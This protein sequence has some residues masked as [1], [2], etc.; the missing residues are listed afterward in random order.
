MR[1]APLDTF[2]IPTFQKAIIEDEEGRPKIIHNAP[3]PQLW[4][5]DI[6]VKTRMVALNPC[7]YKMGTAFPSPGA[8]IGNDF[9]GTVVCI[10]E[11][12]M[13]TSTDATRVGDTVC[14]FVH[15]S[16]PADHSSGAFAEYIRAPADLV[17][18]VPKGLKIEHAATL[19]LSLA[20][21]S[22]ALWENGLG[23]DVDPEN[24][25]EEPFPIL[26]YGASTSTG[27]VA[28]QL[29]KLSGIN[30]IIATCSP[31]NFELVRAYGAT[32]IF[33]YADRDTPNMI[34]KETNGELEYALD[35]IADTD[36]VAYCYASISR[37]GGHYTCLELCPKE[38][39]Q[40]RKTVHAKFPLA[41]EVFGKAVELSRGYERPANKEKRTVA[42]RW[43]QMFQRL[44]DDGK[45]RVP[46]VKVLSPGFES[47]L[48]GLIL[49]Q[50]GSISGQKLVVPVEQ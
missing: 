38:L 32:S 47:I 19:G 50:S 43:F 23:L 45:L 2:A 31:R 35:I 20:T 17:L 4:P 25:A 27:L 24:R 49:L 5:G 13:A 33:N 11:A 28:L 48:D 8:V 10:H 29:L 21:A 18:R 42:V 30:P 1:P 22:V 16:N 7:D 39:L 40:K 37:F 44:L 6:L 41:L 34:R 36:S 3:V 15:G 9:V 26:V 14:G 46:P 12:T